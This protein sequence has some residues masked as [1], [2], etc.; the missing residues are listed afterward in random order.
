MPNKIIW[1]VAAF[2]L[3]VLIGAALMYYYTPSSTSAGQLLTPT[4]QADLNWA[5]YSI[6]SN[7]RDPPPV[8]TGV[9]G[10]WVVPQVEISQNDTFSAVW[11]GIDGFFG[12]TL[13]Q[14]GTEQDS[15]GGVLYYFAWYELLPNDSVTI[16]TINVSPGDIITASI[17]L[18]NSG[19]N[20]W[21]ISISDVSTGQSFSQDF[22]YDSGQ[23]SAEWVVERP[24]VGNDTNMMISTTANFGSVTFSNCK[25][26]IG[27]EHKAFGYF[28]S[29]RIFMYD[30]QGTRLADTS[31]YNSDG[32]SFMITY[33][34]SQ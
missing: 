11:I 16:T 32:S 13:I 27:N 23:L 28:P 1:A 10:S 19:E 5:G 25:A 30:Q 12:K 34:T 18:V 2:T 33:L 29:V 9:S 24:D 26:T 8:V 14:T 22:S 7:F 6:A 17:N 15:A 4:E 21:S 31:N 20:L 3:G